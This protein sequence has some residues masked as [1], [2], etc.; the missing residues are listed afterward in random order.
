MEEELE[1]LEESI[2][3]EEEHE[4]GDHD[5]NKVS[6]TSTALPEGSEANDACG[7][8]GP[9]SFTPA[10]SEEEELDE[11][12]EEQSIDRELSCEPRKSAWLIFYR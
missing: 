4:A 6:G 3:R 10:L 9:F 5:N 2:D 12:E 7:Q 11:L 1:E 8:E